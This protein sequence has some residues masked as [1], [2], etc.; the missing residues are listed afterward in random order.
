MIKDLPKSIGK[1]MLNLS[2]ASR[3]MYPGFLP[4]MLQD[5]ATWSQANDPKALISHEAMK[6][7]YQGLTP[8]ATGDAVGGG[9]AATNLAIYGSSAVGFLGAL[10]EKTNDPRILQL[11]LNAT[12]FYSDLSYPSYLYFNPYD[13]PKTITLNIGEGEHDIY[14]SI[15]ESF[16]HEDVSGSVSIS[17]PAKQAILVVVTPAD[18]TITFDKNKMLVNGV[19]VDYNQSKNSFTYAPRIKAL[20][21]VILHHRKG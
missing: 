5:G 17:I 19:V 4:G 21:P 7:K 3:L 6:E 13:I 2:N 16:I 10:I 11:D 18:G 9:W 12:D 14:E 8:F 1:W 20:E 15:S